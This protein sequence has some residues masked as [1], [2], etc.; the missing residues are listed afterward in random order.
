MASSTTLDDLKSVITPELLSLSLKAHLSHSR[1]TPLNYYTYISD[2]FTAEPSVDPEVLK[3]HTWPALLAL[4]RFPGAPAS[5]T[6]DLLVTKFLPQPEDPTFS[7]AALSLVLFVD[8][9]PRSFCTADGDS[10]T[11]VRYT[12][13]FFGPIALGLARWLLL[14]EKNGG[15]LPVHLRPNTWSRW[16][17]YGVSADYYVLARF[18]FGAPLV[19]SEDA[20]AQR[21]ARQY[22]ED[23][24]IWVEQRF[25]ASDPYRAEQNPLRRALMDD[26]EVYGFPN[27]AMGMIRGEI[28]DKNQIKDKDEQGNPWMSAAEGFFVLG[29]LFD[30]HLPLLAKFGRYPYRN[31]AMGRVHTA[32]EE[33]WMAGQAM[34]KELPED[35]RTR[36]REDVEQSRWSPLGG[37]DGRPISL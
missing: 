20:A 2:M 17:E 7:D 19:H 33:A 21:Q 12:D 32:G 9:G 23:L 34:F 26:E 15:G 25:G 30:V 24:R 1:T 4:S 6:P 29:L 5:L 11:D 22:T 36:I 31:G 28:P 14:D 37:E 10:P 13:G 8:Q 35:L 3:S 27:M 16:E 18:M